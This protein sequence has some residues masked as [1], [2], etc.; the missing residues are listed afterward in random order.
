MGCSR[1]VRVAAAP[2]Q[3]S[4]RRRDPVDV[5]L[6]AEAVSGRPQP[7]LSWWQVTSRLGAT[8]SPELVAHSFEI[9]PLSSVH[10]SAIMIN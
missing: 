10:Y 9:R 5:V 6:A 7:R 4:P 2:R 8:P 3:D 1:R